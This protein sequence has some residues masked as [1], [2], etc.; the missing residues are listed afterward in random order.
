MQAHPLET[1]WKMREMIGGG[2]RIPPECRRVM[3][4]RWM[5]WAVAKTGHGAASSSARSGLVMPAASSVTLSARVLCSILSSSRLAADW[6]TSA[7]A[8]EESTSRAREVFAN[9]FASSSGTTF[10]L[11]E[12]PN[13]EPV[14]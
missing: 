2:A 8:F 7:S 3:M 11:L 6:A 10:D 13:A 1:S 4:E 12:V 14:G 5:R 9:L